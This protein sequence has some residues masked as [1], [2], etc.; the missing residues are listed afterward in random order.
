MYDRMQTFT[1]E[2]L[3]KIHDA[4]LRVLKNIGVM[5][6]DDEAIDIFK[7]AGHKVSGNVVYFS[8]KQISRALESVPAQF[9]LS[10]RNA[11]KSV[12]IG[13]HN[14]ALAPGYGAAFIVTPQGDQRQ[15]T[16][17]DYDDF[18][19]LIQTSKW[20]NVNGFLMVMPSDVPSET[21]YL[22]LLYSNMV[23]CDKPFMGSPL[24][25]MAARDCVNLTG[26]LWGGKENLPDT[27][28]SASLITPL[29]PLQYTSEMAGSVIEFAGNNQVCIFGI[30]LMAGSSATTSLASVIVQQTAEILAGVT[31]TQ[32]VHPGAPVVAGGTSAILDMRT[33][34]L[35]MGA[36]EVARI[37][38]ATMQMAKFYNIPARSGCAVTD[39]HLPDAQAGFESALNLMIAVRNGSNFILHAAGILGSYNAMSFEKFIIDEEICGITHEYL[40]PIVISDESFN[41]DIIEEIGIGGDHLSHPMTL[42]QCRTAFYLPDLA[43]RKGYAGWKENGNQRIDEKATKVLND[44][45]SAYVKPDIDP[46]IEKDLQAY[47]EKRKREF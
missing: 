19:K 44:R 21:A 22:D 23:L 26:I 10:A 2:E 13:G 29:S 7:N 5:F 34:C 43:N 17:S 36:P 46:Q 37:A 9:V 38:A 11:E 30:L 4:S 27:P 45:L 41:L 35:S 20:V 39:A 28:V 3:S 15:A 33:G 12:P 18:C 25:R 42:E 8:E 16:M 1:M 32:L 6:D 47:I 40:K 14:F 31:L 24:S